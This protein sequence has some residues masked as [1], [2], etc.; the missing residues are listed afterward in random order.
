MSLKAIWEAWGPVMVTPAVIV[1]L[2]LVEIAPIK[3]NPWSAIMKFLGSRLNSDVTA[4]LDTM[5]QC[6]AETRKKLDEHIAKDDAQTA[7]L[8]RTQILR[9]NDELL[10]DRRHTKEHF[11][12][13]LGTIKDYEATAPRTRTSRTASASTPS[14]TSTAYMTS[15]WKVTIFCERS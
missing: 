9:F 10:H 12:E 7:S 2:S 3:I 5:Q 13:I 8:W 11:D 14:T 1:L 4:R 15:F 6:Q